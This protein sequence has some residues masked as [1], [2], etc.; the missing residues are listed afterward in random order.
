IHTGATLDVENGDNAGGGA[1]L[2]GVV[3]TLDG[4]LDLGDVASGAVLTLDHGTSIS[5]TGTLNITSGNTLGGEPAGGPPLRGCAV[6]GASG[7]G[8]GIVV[9]EATTSGSLLSLTNVTTHDVGI[10]LDHNSELDV[11]GSVDF[12][13]TSVS[14]GRIVFGSG[15]VLN[16]G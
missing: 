16:V 2:D 3:V 14:G 12:Y 7:G 8:S 10:T 4:N 11:N 13:D 9:G 1:T 15:A 6:F 5:S